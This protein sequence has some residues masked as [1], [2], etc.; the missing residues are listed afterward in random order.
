MAVQPTDLV[1][2]ERA[3][4]GYKAPVSALPSSSGG[5]DAWTR[6]YL[7][8]DHVNGTTSFQNMGG[9]TSSDT[10]IDILA[11]QHFMIEAEILLQTVATANLPRLQWNW[12]SGLAWGTCELEYPLTATTKSTLVGFPTSTSGVLQMPV[13]TAPVQGSPYLARAFFKGKAGAAAVTIALQL[14]AESAAASAAIA[15]AG[16]EFRYRTYA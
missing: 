6:I 1:Y 2:V 16:S 8:A 11:N 5:T 15:K 4:V 12:F 3:G 9:L 13:G 10:S 14:A 7:P